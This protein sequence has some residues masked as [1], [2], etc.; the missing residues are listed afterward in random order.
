MLVPFKA[1][2]TTLAP[3][4]CKLST[5]LLSDLEHPSQTTSPY[6]KDKRT[7][8]LIQISSDNGSNYISMA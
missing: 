8:D 4:I 5:K 7:K 6:S 2:A 3:S 1:P